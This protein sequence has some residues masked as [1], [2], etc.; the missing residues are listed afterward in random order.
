MEEVFQN[1]AEGATKEHE[2]E[3]GFLML[4]HQNESTE[5]H[6]INRQP[7]RSYIQLHFGLKGSSRF[8]F[9][10]GRYIL[11]VPEVK[12]CSYT[13]LKKIYQYTWRF[14]QSH[15]LCPFLLLY[16]NSMVCFLQKRDMLIF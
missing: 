9:N 11:E 16:Q 14:N 2:I 13:I 15:G 1:N 7:G 5:V 3:R 8:L 12:C 10:E 4:V 6:Y